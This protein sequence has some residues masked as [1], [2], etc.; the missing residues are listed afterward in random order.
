[1]VGAAVAVAIIGLAGPVAGIALPGVI[2]A[3]TLLLPAL[4]GATAAAVLARDYGWDAWARMG[5]FV[6]GAAGGA[7]VGMTN[8][9]M[10]SP[11]AIQEVAS[12]AAAVGEAANATARR[13]AAAEPVPAR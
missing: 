13:A 4:A 7:A 6:S 12:I 8:A 3:E 1:M 5:A 11:Q 9:G 2:A 10:I